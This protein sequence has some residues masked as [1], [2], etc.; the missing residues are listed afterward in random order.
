MKRLLYIDKEKWMILAAICIA[1]AAVCMSFVAVP[2]YVYA[3]TPVEGT[4]ID[5][6]GAGAHCTGGWE[7]DHIAF[8]GDDGHGHG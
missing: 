4:I 1:L 6:P 2:T 3:Y 8:P 7:Q 5:G